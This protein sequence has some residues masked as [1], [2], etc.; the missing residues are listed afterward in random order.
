MGPFFKKQS[1]QGTSPACGFS[2][3]VEAYDPRAG[4]SGETEEPE[5]AEPEVRRQGPQ[6][7]G[8]TV[9]AAAEEGEIGPSLGFCGGKL[10]FCR[11]PKGQVPC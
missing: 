8:A 11:A 9:G 10:V 5:P 7:P 6:L 1:K 2:D 3:E 4:Y